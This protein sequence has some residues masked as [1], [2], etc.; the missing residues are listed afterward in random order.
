MSGRGATPL[1]AASVVEA[2]HRC[3]FT[4]IVWLPDSEARF[5][6]D[7]LAADPDL[8]L[9]PVCR[10]GEAIAIAAGLYLGGQ[11]PAVLYQNTGFF[12]AGDSLRGIALDLHLRGDGAGRGLP[13][14]VHLRSDRRPGAARG[15]GPARARA[16]DSRAQGGLRG[17]AGRH[18]RPADQRSLS[19]PA[20][21]LAASW[22]LT[23]AVLTPA[24]LRSAPPVGGG[25]RAAVGPMAPLMKE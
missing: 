5:L 22:G 18:R 17:T 8:T 2:F 25:G 11:Q 3:G 23:H 10:E 4:H 1:R 15:G 19:A 24:S 21:A 13:R 6:Y 20:G 16:D 7:A 9:V 14:G 12:E